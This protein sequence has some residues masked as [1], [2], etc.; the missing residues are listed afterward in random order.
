MDYRQYLQILNDF[1]NT[2]PVTAGILAFF[3]ILS[4]VLT[5]VFLAKIREGKKLNVRLNRFKAQEEELYG[6]KR[7]LERFKKVSEQLNQQQVNFS[8]RLLMIEKFT[9]EINSH[10]EKKAIINSLL[11]GFKKIIGAKKAEI[12]FF[13]P[14]S[15]KLVFTAAM[16][17]T[18]EEM[19]SMDISSEDGVIGYVIDHLGVVS[20]EEMKTDFHLRELEAKSKLKTVMAGALTSPDESKVIGVVNISALEGKREV[21]KEDIRAFSIL[22]SLTSLA[23]ENAELFQRTKM[24]AI[25]DG[26][27][28]LH[29]HRYF[30]DFLKDELDRHI[31]FKHSLS[32]LISDIDHFKKFNDTYGHQVGDFVLRETARIFKANIRKKIDLAARYGGEEFVVVLPETNA[33]G[34]L[35]LADRIRQRIEE[36]EFYYEQTENKFR[37]TVSIG[38]ATYPLHAYNPADLIKRADEA[39]YE[40]KESGRNKVCLAQ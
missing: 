15:E 24:L 36:T 3:I 30:Q 11:E 18:R 2:Q 6:L 9:Q 16:D 21:E 26:L 29:N 13:E 27:T 25:M 20:S 1:V 39:L 14:G 40:A 7:E 19:Q 31:R 5:L 38:V 34:A 10:L 4:L 32:I 23:L 35:K 17:W 12:L 28:K 22:I 33:S 8:S 37:V